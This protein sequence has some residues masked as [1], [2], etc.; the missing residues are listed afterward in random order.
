M[1]SAPVPKFACPLCGWNHV[2][3]RTGAS[4]V[5]KGKPVTKHG[6]IFRFGQAPLEGFGFLKWVVSY[7]HCSDEKAAMGQKR[8]FA[9]DS[10]DTIESLVDDP[11]WSWAVNDVYDRAKELIERVDKARRLSNGRE[12]DGSER[13]EG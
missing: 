13:A 6:V 3:K 7:G 1:P 11:A 10:E 5:S 9:V 12:S 8:G 4:A 2:V